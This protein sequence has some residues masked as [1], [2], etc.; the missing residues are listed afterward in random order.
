MEGGVI[1]GLTLIMAWY[2]GGLRMCWC[3][4]YCLAPVDE[5]D[6]RPSRREG[7]KHIER[8]GG[9]EGGRNGRGRGVANMEVVCTGVLRLLSTGHR[10]KRAGFMSTR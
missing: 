10:S 2:T 6:K 4:C 3:L 9:K 7:D 1:M 8:Q 5:G